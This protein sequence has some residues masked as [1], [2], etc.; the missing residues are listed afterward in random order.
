MDTTSIQTS[1]PTDIDPH[2][3]LVSDQQLEMNEMLV[4]SKISAITYL[5][6][7]VLTC[8]FVNI[9]GVKIAEPTIWY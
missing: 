5:S 3:K 6:L 1:F 4:R 7:V 9:Y 8:E 2:E